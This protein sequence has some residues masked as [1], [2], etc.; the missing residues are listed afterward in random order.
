M[1]Q[2]SIHRPKAKV[3]NPERRLRSLRRWAESA[4]G[5]YPKDVGEH[6]RNWKIPVLDRLVQPPI[7]KKEWQAQ[8]L[9][10][11]LLV[12][13]NFI[14]AKP[15]SE[16][17]ESW[18]AVLITYPFM[19]HSEVT[20]FYER[21]YY[22][23]FLYKADLITGKGLCAEM[24]VKIP[25]GMIEIGCHVSWEGE[26]ENGNPYKYTEERWTIGESIDL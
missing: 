6:Y 26:D 4:K 24:G 23:R 13:S 17:G 11:L 7:A 3:R 21:K 16:I 25:Y 9:E 5:H 20:A 22:E 1:R 19:W 2:L 10:S 8:A 15:K 12:A 14:E 18:I